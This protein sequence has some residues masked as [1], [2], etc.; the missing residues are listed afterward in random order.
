MNPILSII[1]ESRS[2][3]EKIR[4]FRSSLW[5]TS[6]VKFGYIQRINEIEDTLK[7]LE[8]EMKDVMDDLAHLDQVPNQAQH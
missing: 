5:N 6:Q 1:N 2:L 3:R 4:R 7:S 8:Q